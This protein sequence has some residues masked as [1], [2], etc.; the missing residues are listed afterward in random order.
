MLLSVA[1]LEDIS[2]DA[3]PYPLSNAENPIKTNRQKWNQNSMKAALL[4]VN[5]CKVCTRS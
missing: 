3:I 1:Q 5:S 2:T 4:L